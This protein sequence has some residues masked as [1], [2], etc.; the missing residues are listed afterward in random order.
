MAQFREFADNLYAKR[1]VHER[2]NELIGGLVLDAELAAEGAA[3]VADE[4]RRGG[5]EQVHWQAASWHDICLSEA[6]PT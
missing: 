5:W 3:D 4:K 1:L 6:E 2:K